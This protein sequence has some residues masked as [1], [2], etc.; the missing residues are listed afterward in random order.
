MKPA[1]LRTVIVLAAVLLL[2]TAALAFALTSQSPRASQIPTVVTSVS[3]SE[4]TSASVAQT[5]TVIPSSSATSTAS[6]PVRRTAKPPATSGSDRQNGSSGSGSSS[7]SSREVVTPK[8]RDNNEGESEGSNSG[9][10]KGDSGTEKSG[11]SGEKGSDSGTPDN[12]S[13]PQS[14][15]RSSLTRAQTSA[16]AGRDRSSGKNL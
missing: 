14:I 11:S 13:T 5:P 7:G 3:T 1:T 16:E 6:K 10:E 9:T 4:T 12:A 15:D 2:G 8:V